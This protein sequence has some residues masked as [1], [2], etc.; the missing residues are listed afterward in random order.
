MCSGRTEL[1]VL[2]NST[3]LKEISDIKLNVAYQPVLSIETHTV[4]QFLLKLYYN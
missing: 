4:L 1:E 3:V 2:M